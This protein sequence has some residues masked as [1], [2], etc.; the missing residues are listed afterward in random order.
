MR[1]RSLFSTPLLALVLAIVLGVGLGFAVQSAIQYFTPKPVPLNPN[2]ELRETA[3]ASPPDMD[4]ENAISVFKNNKA[5][6]VNVDTVVQFRQMNQLQEQQQ[7]TG[8]GFFWDNEGRIVTNFHVV[9]DAV[10]NKSVK[11]R[12]VQADQSA[13]DATIVGIAPNYDLAV[14]QI[15]PDASEKP[16]T[17]GKSSDLQVGQK[18]YAIGNPF[19]YSLTL[20]EGI[21]SALD[22]QIQSPAD[23]IITGVIQTDASINPGNSGGPLLNKDGQLI[24]VNTAISSP[25]GGNVG[26]GFAIPVDT[27]NRVVTEIIRTGR[28]Q[29]PDLGLQ[30]VDLQRLRRAGYLR[31]VMIDV[32][33]ANGPAAK[34]GLQGVRVDERKRQVYPGDLILKIDGQTISSNREFAQVIANHEVG[35]KVTFTI[36]RDDE[37]REVELTIGGN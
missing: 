29:Q 23:R 8:S 36:E 6:V 7:G 24:G 21:V 31:G 15:Q 34:A 20:T 30:L 26:I 25:T 37:Q 17:L 10:L 9:K 12:V 35:D 13:H 1:Q 19:A 2:A 16:I 14:L 5:S 18:A 3:E 33:E 28:V 11:L 22:R 27:V 32:V 4:E